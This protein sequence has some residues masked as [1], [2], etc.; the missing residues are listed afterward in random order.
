VDLKRAL[1]EE[2]ANKD[3]RALFKRY[4]QQV[5]AHMDGARVVVRSKA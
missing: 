2:P 1:Q 3:V 4:K 5:R